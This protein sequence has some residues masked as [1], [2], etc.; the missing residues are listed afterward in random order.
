MICWGLQASRS[1]KGV[2][3]EMKDPAVVEATFNKFDYNGNGSEQP[4]H[5]KKRSVPMRVKL[6]LQPAAA[7]SWRH[8]GVENNAIK[9]TSRPT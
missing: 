3:R 7:Y 2:V 8:R 4:K 6:W 1:L 5:K 9:K